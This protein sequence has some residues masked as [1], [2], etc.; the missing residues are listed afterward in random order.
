MRA[1]GVEGWRRAVGNQ[2]VRKDV[3]LIDKLLQLIMSQRHD[4]VH[5]LIIPADLDLLLPFFISALTPTLIHT[6]I[7]GSF[8]PLFSLLLISTIIQFTV[9]IRRYHVI[10]MDL[11]QLIVILLVVGFLGMALGMMLKLRVGG[12]GRFL[13]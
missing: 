8:P 6:V 9:K 12:R 4:L 5:E 13:G 7:V 3:V 2:F 10:L 1:R 11:I